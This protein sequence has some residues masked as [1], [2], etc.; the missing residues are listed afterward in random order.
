MAHAIT[1]EVTAIVSGDQ[2]PL[3]TATGVFVGLNPVGVPL[4][5]SVGVGDGP[6]VTVNVAVAT[7]EEPEAVTV[8]VPGDTGGT[9]IITCATPAIVVAIPRSVVPK[10]TLTEGSGNPRIYAITTFPEGP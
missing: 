1:A 2:N 6:S 10:V 3:F 7:P 9:T 5:A 8:Y 4:G